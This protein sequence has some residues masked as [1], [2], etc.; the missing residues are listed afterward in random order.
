MNEAIGVRD[1]MQD[2]I[3]GLAAIADRYDGYIIDVW[4]TLYDGGQV[5]P[6][7]L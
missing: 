7:A 6:A 4:G 3:D 2:R 1:G 5:F